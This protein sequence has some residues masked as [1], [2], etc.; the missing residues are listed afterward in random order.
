MEEDLKY[1]VMQD[2][3]KNKKVEDD[4]KLI[5]ILMNLNF[6]PSSWQLLGH[7]LESGVPGNLASYLIY[8]P[9]EDVCFSDKVLVNAVCVEDKVEDKIED[10]VENE[11]ENEV[12]DDVEDKFDDEHKVENEIEAPPPNSNF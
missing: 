2:D 6:S 7:R 9:I 8:I 10:K 5:L 1:L 4:L 11:V 3:N 12:E